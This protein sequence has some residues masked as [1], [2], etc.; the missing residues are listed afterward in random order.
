MDKCLETYKTILSTFDWNFEFS[1]D[2]RVFTKWNPILKELY[3]LQSKLDKD[4]SIWKSYSVNKGFGVP[5]P[6]IK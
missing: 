3:I 4:G 1:D 5:A 2:Q 6:Y